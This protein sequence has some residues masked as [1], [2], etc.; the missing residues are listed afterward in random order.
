MSGGDARHHAPEGTGDLDRIAALVE[1][2]FAA[3]PSPDDDDIVEAGCCAE[4]DALGAWLR[5]RSWQEVREDLRRDEANPDPSFLLRPQAFRY[6]LPAY[7]LAALERGA[8]ETAERRLFS[9]SHALAPE[10][11]GLEMFRTKYL[12]V[13]APTERAAI[14][15]YFTALTARRSED[16]DLR[17][18]CIEEALRVLWSV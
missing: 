7:L 8:P 16:A 18:P 1:D 2:A 17:R 4:C 14:R 5:G 11:T 6:F 13:F 9:P 12:G 3:C 10:S 15:A